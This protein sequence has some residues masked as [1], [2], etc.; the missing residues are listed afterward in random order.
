MPLKLSVTEKKPRFFTITLVGSLD[1]NTHILLDDKIDQLVK[2]GSAKVITLDM[3]GVNY[4]SSM[5]VRCTFRAK[6]ALA[7]QNGTFMMVNLQPPVK[8]VF[9]II[10]ALPSMNIFAN[11]QEMDDYLT[12]MQSKVED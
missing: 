7:K 1:T 4:I 10:D 8:K 5:G 6:R 9:E 12:R 11:M 2:E 3:G